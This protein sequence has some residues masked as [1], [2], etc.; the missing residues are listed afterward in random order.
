VAR[1]EILSSLCGRRFSHEIL[2]I[3]SLNKTYL[4]M[5]AADIPK[6]QEKNKVSTGHTP[7]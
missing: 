6:W 2:T 5:T 7:K 3:W 4:M 1:L